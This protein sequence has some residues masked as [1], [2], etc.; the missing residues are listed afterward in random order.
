[1][2]AAQNFMSRT[3]GAGSDY[4]QVLNSPKKMW[5]TISPCETGTYLIVTWWIDHWF[6]R[7]CVHSLKQI[8][9]S[10]NLPFTR[11]SGKSVQNFI[12]RLL[13]VVGRLLLVFSQCRN[14][15]HFRLWPFWSRFCSWSSW[16]QISYRCCIW[17]FEYVNTLDSLS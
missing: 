4:W 1:M 3:L 9:D 10:L 15:K 14:N 13:M 6:L 17:C 11:E 2:D 16:W 12:R 8:C 5:I 7:F